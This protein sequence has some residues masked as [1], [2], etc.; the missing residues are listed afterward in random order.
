MPA[1]ICFQPASMLPA[2]CRHWHGGCAERFQLGD[3]DAEFV[4]AL[5]KVFPRNRPRPLRGELIFDAQRVVAVEQNEMVA[6]WQF[7]PGFDDQRMLDGAVEFANVAPMN[8]SVVMV[9]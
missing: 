7:H 6:D 1:L 4:R 9:F 8:F 3:F 2:A 5:R